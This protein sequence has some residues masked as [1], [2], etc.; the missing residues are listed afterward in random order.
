MRNHSRYEL[1]V[2]GSLS[3]A[4]PLRQRPLPPALTSSDALIP[5]GHV[6]LESKLGEGFYGVVYR[7]L[8]AGTPVAVKRL[9]HNRRGAEDVQAF[10]DEAR[11]LRDLRH[12]CIT[13]FY[14]VTSEESLMVTELLT[15][16]LFHAI[17]TD[18]MMLSHRLCRRIAMDISKGAAYMHSLSPPIIHRDMSSGNILL[19]GEVEQLEAIVAE[20]KG[21][22]GETA[23]LSDFGLSRPV[24]DDMTA[25]PGNL[26]YMAPELFRGENYTEKVDIY[27][28]AIILWEMFM[29]EKPF[30]KAGNPQKVANNVS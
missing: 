30:L 21:K 16:S 27:A 5:R 17:H 26:S 4:R 8:W 23:K 18:N 14:G 29:G 1:P 9:K 19:T 13:T 6:T 25:R 10:Q 15:T 3:R 7:G 20:T 28:F 11:V 12:P 2:L 24:S 22:G